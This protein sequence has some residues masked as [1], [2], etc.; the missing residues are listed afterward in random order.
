MR[1]PYCDSTDVKEREMS[2][3]E[4]D[5]TIAC[6]GFDPFGIKF[7]LQSFEKYLQKD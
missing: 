6:E 5:Y 1:C 4:S 2:I 7:F 3:F